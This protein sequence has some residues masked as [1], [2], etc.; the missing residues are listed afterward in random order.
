MRAFARARPGRRLPGAGGR[1]PPGH[2]PRVGRGAHALPHRGQVH[3]L[4]QRE[5][6]GPRADAHARA[7]RRAGARARGVRARGLLDRQGR[8]PLAR[9]RG[10]RVRG[11]ARHQPLQERGRRHARHG[12][13]R[14]PDERHGHRGQEEAAARSRRRRRSTPPRC[15]PPPPPRGSRRRAPCAS[16]S[17]STWT[18]SSATRASTTRCTRSLSTSTPSS[19]ALQGVPEL[20][21][22]AAAIAS[23]AAASHARREGDHR[24]PADPPDGRG[25]PEEAEA[26]GV[27]ALQPRGAPL[28][29]HALRPGEDRRHH[30]DHRGE[31]RAVRRQGR[32]P[33]DPGLPRHLPLRAQEGRA[34]AGA[35]R[36]GRG[37]LPGRRDDAEGHAAP[38]AL[39]AGQ[40]HPGDGEARAGHQG[41]PPR[42][43]RA[44]A[45]GQVRGRRAAASRR[46]WAAPSSRRSPP[47][48]SASPRPT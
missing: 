20:R 22:R 31:Q 12:G 2:R 28:P 40:A 5:V 24:P 14:R 29:G 26:R 25:R 48:R 32:R 7:H 41:D 27:E 42:H 13:R 16:P 33:R 9:L 8:L 17:R 10:G 44:P 35:Q 45:R 38:G 37:R 11:R 23:A 19:S 39:L 34:A 30:G 21:A 36:A 43:H 47:T 4:R 3:R 15:R 6:G 18:A 1:V 46:S